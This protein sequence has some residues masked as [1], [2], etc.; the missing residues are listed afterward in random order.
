MREVVGLVEEGSFR[1]IH[2]AHA[3]VRGI[4]AADAIVRAAR[5]EGDQ[6][7]LEGLRG[8]VLQQRHFGADVVE[9]IDVETDLRS[10]LGASSLQLGA[11]GKDEYEIGAEGAK[12][13]PQSALEAGPVREQQDDRRNAPRHSEHGQHAAALVVA[14][15]VVGLGCEIDDHGNQLLASSS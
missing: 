13:R 7:V 5:A 10:C 14:Q 4:N 3:S 1:D 9:I 15:R 11:A 12:C 6:A 8:N 2:L